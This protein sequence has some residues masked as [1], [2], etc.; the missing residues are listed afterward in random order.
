[1]TSSSEA[2]GTESSVGVHV[3]APSLQFGHHEG[4]EGCNTLYSVEGLV[5]PVTP[6]SRALAYSVCPGIRH[7]HVDLHQV[8][9][10]FC[11]SGTKRKKWVRISYVCV[12][13]CIYVY[14]YIYPLR[15]PGSGAVSMKA[16][17]TTSVSSSVRTTVRFQLAC[18]YGKRSGQQ[19]RM[20]LSDL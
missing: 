9:S 19:K 14:I 20:H 17:V 12:Y 3:L 5:S 11:G 18:P 15:D 10:R 1:M 2:R 6:S 7:V 8:L 16:T 13:I 4:C